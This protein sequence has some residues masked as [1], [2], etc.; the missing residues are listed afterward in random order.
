MP[1]YLVAIVEEVTD[2]EGLQRYAGGAAELMAR[3]GGRYLFASFGPRTLEGGPPPQ[4]I[5]V[6]EFPDAAGIE[7]FWNAPEYV[8]LRDLRHR[9]ARV[10]IY[11]ADAPPGA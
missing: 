11:A 3:F 1:T 7:A 4:A 10:R 8:P 2:P 5:A 6:A 9:S